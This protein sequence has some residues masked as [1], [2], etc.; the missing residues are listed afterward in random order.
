[1]SYILDLTAVPAPG[2]YGA[3][4]EAAGASAFKVTVANAAVRAQL[5]KG[6][7]ASE[8]GEARFLLP[9]VH[10][11]PDPADGIRFTAAAPIVTGKEPR[12]AV[13]AYT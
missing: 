11:I 10:V 8:W 3:T 6:F 12:V 5:A 4:L 9:G 1:M 2:T 13:E 7:G